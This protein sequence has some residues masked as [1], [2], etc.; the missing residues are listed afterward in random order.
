M[1]SKIIPLRVRCQDVRV[2][3]YLARYGAYSDD[4]TVAT[5]VGT[6]NHVY[7]SGDDQL[8]GRPDRH[9]CFRG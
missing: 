2:F 3:Q 8:G 9:A 7:R 1:R 4:L 6:V 5:R